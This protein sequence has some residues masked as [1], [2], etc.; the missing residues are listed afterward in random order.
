MS[1]Q[2]TQA[3]VI[4]AVNQVELREIEVPKIEEGE[5]LIR[6]SHTQLS[7]G[8]EVSIATGQRMESARFPYVPGYMGVGRIETCAKGV[9]NF[10][11][12]DLVSFLG[13]RV[14]PPNHAVWGGHQGMIVCSAED[15]LPCPP[16]LNSRVAC[17]A[18]LFA[19]GLH[20][21]ELA[22]VKPTD[23]VVVIGQGL[24]GAS[25]AQAARAR[26]AFVIASE[27]DPE[28]RRLA[29]EFAADVVVDP[30]SEKLEEILKTHVAPD[31]GGADVVI[32]STGAA[33]LIDGAMRL[34]RTH[35]KFVH[36][37]WYS[38]NVSYYFMVP[39]AR[40]ITALY[41][42]G[43]G[44]LRTKEAAMRLA[45]RGIFKVEPYLSHVIPAD[46]AVESYKLAMSAQR[47]QIL[48]M[49]FDWNS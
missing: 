33:K 1:T 37:G 2:R 43:F 13:G 35:G 9:T 19:V 25:A 47:Q 6:T 3:L 40:E 39:H 5:V 48:G 16:S 44:G 36:Q 4:P 34:V 7:M 42:T 22:E 26:G 17:M 12:G 31:A 45:A 41:P 15:L 29:K 46:K 30:S 10:R 14:L 49:V 20:G 27:P 23:V 21:V 32:E 38:G 18:P 28:R 8:T 11:E 24:I